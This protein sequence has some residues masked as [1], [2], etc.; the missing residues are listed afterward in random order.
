MFGGSLETFYADGK[1]ILLNSMLEIEDQN[2][3]IH[4][5]ASLR[6]RQSDIIEVINGKGGRFRCRVEECTRKKLVAM[7]FEEV[8]TDSDYGDVKLTVAVSLLNKNSKMKLLAEKL[9]EIGIFELIPLISE[10][11]AFPKMKTD[12]LRSSMISALKQCGGSTDV[13][14]SDTI[15]FIELLGLK[16]F[17]RKFYADMNGIKLTENELKGKI[18]AVVGPE[19]GLTENEKDQLSKNGFSALRLNK[20]V[21]R[22]ETAAIITAS[23]FLL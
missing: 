10:R 1:E 5:Y 17:D 2:E 8:K 15:S 19:G 14:L 18:L 22:A 21:L 7:P 4:A 6:I 23:R 11:T 9:T 12:S 20:R 16:G 3:V 13:V